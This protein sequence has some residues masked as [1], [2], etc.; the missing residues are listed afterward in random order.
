[1][2]TTQALLGLEKR[3]HRCGGPNLPMDEM[4]LRD[5]D[6]SDRKGFLQG[7]PALGPI[8]GTHPYPILILQGI[9]M[10]VLGG[11]SHDL[12]VGNNHG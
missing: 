7:N 3:Y 4:L 1:M 11:S 10:G 5:L 6:A 8:S 2:E 12:Y 9:R